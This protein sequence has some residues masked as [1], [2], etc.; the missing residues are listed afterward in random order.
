MSTKDLPTEMRWATMIPLIGGSA[1]GCAK[2][3]GVLPQFHL[4][5]QDFAKH[6]AHL[7]RYW[8]KVPML[9]LDKK[10]RKEVSMLIKQEIDFLTSVCPCAGLSTMNICK[11]GRATRG[12]DAVQND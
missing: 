6:Q 2:S 7:K 5:Y 11:K 10:S 8:P 12:S 4:S 3:T 9:Y 1:I